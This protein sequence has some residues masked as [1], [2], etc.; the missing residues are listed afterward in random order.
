MINLFLFPFFLIVVALVV[1]W[2]IERVNTY[3]R[4]RL[5]IEAHQAETSAKRQ[6]ERYY[7]AR[8]WEVIANSK[9]ERPFTQEE[10][11]AIEAM[12]FGDLLKDD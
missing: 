2:I 7:R 12:G 1:F 5:L 9:G 6:L 10:R 11:D 8:T 4:H 3:K